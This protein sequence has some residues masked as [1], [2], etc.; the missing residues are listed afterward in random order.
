MTLSDIAIIFATLCGPIAAVQAQKWLEKNRDVRRRK[1]HI[2]RTLMATR[3]SRVS[4]EHVQALNMIN[5]EF[6]GGGQR[7]RAV[8]EAWNEYR[9]HLNTQYAKEAFQVWSGRGDELFFELLY[10][11]S[12]CVGLPFERAHIKKSAYSP[13]AH[14]SLEQDQNVI[15]SGLV[16]LFSNKFAIPILATPSKEESDEQAALRKLLTESL[17]RKRPY[18]VEIVNSPVS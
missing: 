11:M 10:H 2:F 16:A 15:R 17:S 13:I 5:F 4:A 6:Y 1:E 9:D 8:R 18:K 12:H 14:G 3:A 7:D